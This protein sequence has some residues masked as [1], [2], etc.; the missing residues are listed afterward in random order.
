M[1]RRSQALSNGVL[2]QDK[3]QWAQ[4]GTQEA[5]SEHKA[6]LLCCEGDGQAAQRL[7]GLFL[8]DLEKLPSHTYGQPTLGGLTGAEA[9]PEGPRGPLKS[10]DFCDSSL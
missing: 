10:E 6:A 7:W 1:R 5:S 9:E 2:C 3:R 8:G 4:T